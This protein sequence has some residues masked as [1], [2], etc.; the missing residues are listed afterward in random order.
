MQ[1]AVTILYLGNQTWQ[2]DHLFLGSQAKQ[3]TAKDLALLSPTGMQLPQQN[4]TASDLLQGTLR[5]ILAPTFFI[6]SDDLKK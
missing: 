5:K 6:P 3:V 4:I 2:S 1:M